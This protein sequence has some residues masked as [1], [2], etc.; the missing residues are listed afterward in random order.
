MEEKNKK[1]IKNSEIVAL[2][3][4]I[5]IL[6][7]FIFLK[8]SFYDSKFACDIIRNDYEN[9]L[10][11]DNMKFGEVFGYCKE[12]DGLDNFINVVFI[13]FLHIFVG[14][15]SIVGVKININSLKSNSNAFNQICYFIYTLIIGCIEL[16]F[17][18]IDKRPFSL[19]QN[20]F[21]DL[22]EKREL[23]ISKIEGVKISGIL[24]IIYS[25]L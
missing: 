5:F 2:V 21:N 10:N 22:K 17:C 19:D 7:H 23:A 25:A 15:F 6:I 4:Q 16:Y 12:N 20:D 1:I 18:I 8:D 9:K 13:F 14:I 3:L 24:L 11:F